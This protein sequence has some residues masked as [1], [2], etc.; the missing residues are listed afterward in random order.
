MTDERKQEPENTT[1]P[2]LQSG[3][4]A[5]IDALN[6]IH[7][8]ENFT[9]EIWQKYLIAKEEMIDQIKPSVSADSLLV[10]SQSRSSTPG[11]QQ[12][13]IELQELKE[14][15]R[16]RERR[17]RQKLFKNIVQQVPEAQLATGV[18]LAALTVIEDIVKLIQVDIPAHIR[19]TGKPNAEVGSE[20]TMDCLDAT[21]RKLITEKEVTPGL[22]RHSYLVLDRVM[23]VLP[24]KKQCDAEAYFTM[25]LYIVL[26]RN[27]KSQNDEHEQF[28]KMIKDLRKHG[29]EHS[30]FEVGQMCLILANKL[31]LRAFRYYGNNNPTNEEKENFYED[32][33]NI[34]DAA[35]PLLAKHR[36]IAVIRV[37][38]RIR[39]FFC[40]IAHAI[41]YG[42]F[43]HY[44][45]TLDDYAHN[46]TTSRAKTRA[47][48]DFA[49]DKIARN[50]GSTR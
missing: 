39:A 26:F 9:D 48:S 10:R 18:P 17:R 41:S 29:K 4:K 31:H 34:V 35:R 50:K 28:G 36:A 37:L 1:S 2:E 22:L 20:D 13:G 46:R 25:S 40:G 27:N 8:D 19:N 21:V 5:I 6:L 30:N 12:H 7:S 3:L 23:Q 16:S 43:G 38:N 24:E 45:R 49:A 11:E 33:K 47:I 42:I 14:E 32:I 44:S 15:D